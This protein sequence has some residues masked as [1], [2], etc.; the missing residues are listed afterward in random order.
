MGAGE[1]QGPRAPRAPGLQGVVQALLGS[2]QF[3]L[4]KYRPHPQWLP[5]GGA[6]ALV[7]A[8][9]RV[10]GESGIG[11]LEPWGGRGGMEPTALALTEPFL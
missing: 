6:R 5:S 2:I 8:E 1:T 10:L 11:L 3:P 4:E 9:N 7:W